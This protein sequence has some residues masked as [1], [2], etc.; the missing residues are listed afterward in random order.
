MTA[1]V[2]NLDNNGYVERILALHAE[3]HRARVHQRV[4]QETALAVERARQQVAALNEQKDE[5]LGITAHDLRTPLTVIQGF[6]MTMALYPEIQESEELSEFTQL[7]ETT[8]GRMLLLINDLLDIAK[9][10]SGKLELNCNPTDLREVIEQNA[11]LH[12]P[13]AEG[14]GIQLETE[15]PEEPVVSEVDTERMGQVLTNLLSNAVKFSESGTTITVR[16]AHNGDE[17][18]VAVQDQ[19]RGIPP[20]D[21]GHVFERFRQTGTKSTAGEK[22]TGLGLA[23]VKKIVELHGG[24][25]TVE[26]R[27]DEGSTF[28]VH[29]PA[30]Q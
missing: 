13:L 9:I 11:V 10:E 5:F 22:G 25:I 7:I 8:S 29:L 18:S 16:L 14:K 21:I 30:A 2:M 20:E 1:D 24:R 17:A 28:T 3:A 15:L 6:A 23:I 12:R 26:S 19:G 4:L 27:L